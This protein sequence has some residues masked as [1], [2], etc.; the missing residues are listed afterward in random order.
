MDLVSLTEN[1]DT[2]SPM[3]RA[4]LGFMAVFTQLTR[5]TIAENVKAGLEQRARK[6]KCGPL[7][8]LPSGTI[9]TRPERADLHRL[10]SV[11]LCARRSAL[12]TSFHCAGASGHTVR[13]ATL[14]QDNILEYLAYRGPGAV[15]EVVVRA[16][17]K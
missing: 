17:A 3:G 7:V 12:L 14:Y 16:P 2:T 1:L 15:G 8:R 9:M 5:E 10:S 13:H 6:G 11:R 4:M